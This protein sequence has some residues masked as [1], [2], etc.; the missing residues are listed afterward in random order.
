MAKGTEPKKSAVEGL[1]LGLYDAARLI[2]KSIQHVRNLVKEG[3]IPEPE[4]GRYLATD[5]AGGALRARDAEDRRSSKS[6]AS[7]RLHEERAEEIR[8]R[9]MERKG[10]MLIEAQREAL[11]VI[12]EFAGQLRADLMAIPAR[13]TDDLALRR[14][15]EDKIDAAFG[16]AS[17]RAAA[18]ADRVEA[19]GGPLADPPAAAPRRMGGKQPR[20]SAKRRRAGRA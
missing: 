14:S 6:A 1:R 4:D 17:K 8:V 18:A 11:H 12:D 7:S 9:T 10:T 19:P 20:V 15:I 5:V 2:G 13:V 16:E 3:F